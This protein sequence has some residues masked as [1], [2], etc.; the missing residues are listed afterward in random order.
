MSAFEEPIENS[1]YEDTNLVDASADASLSAEKLER[2]NNELSDQI[3]GVTEDD[4]NRA[5]ENETIANIDLLDKFNETLSSDPSSASLD[6]ADI[7]SLKELASKIRTLRSQG[8]T[9]GES[10][11]D[12]KEQQDKIS[13]D[14]LNKTTKPIKQ[15]SKNIKANSDKI[16]KGSEKQAEI[17]NKTKTVETATEE[18]NQAIESGDP[19]QINAAEERLNEA[20]KGLRDVL[21]KIKELTDAVEGSGS[22]WKKTLLAML[23]FFAKGGFLFLMLWIVSKQITGCYLFQGGNRSKLDNCSD[24]YAKDNNKSYCSCG[25]KA[26]ITNYT[27]PD[28]TKI[29]NDCKNPYCLGVTGCDLTLPNCQY[30]N[31]I[32]LQCNDIANLTDSKSIYYSY[33]EYSPLSIINKLFELGSDIAGEI[34]KL[35]QDI[36]ALLQAVLKYMGIFF[37]VI[38]VMYILFQVIQ[39]IFSKIRRQS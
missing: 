5:V 14:G 24:W 31:G 29:L 17:D 30:P 21:D 27:N 8:K 2:T 1:T 9:L 23:M 12:L 15:M 7:E 3:E 18:L 19:E 6:P 26:T 28:C 32:R 10:T 33:Q 13:D 4:I 36:A 39:M 20:I 37:G 25:T 22:S 35:P 34:P 16:T 11:A 38:V